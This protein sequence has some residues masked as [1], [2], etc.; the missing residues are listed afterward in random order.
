M[1]RRG[2]DEE[3][4][5]N[6]SYNHPHPNPWSPSAPPEAGKPPP[7]MGRELYMRFDIGIIFATF[8]SEI[9]SNKAMISWVIESTPYQEKVS[10][11]VDD[12]AISA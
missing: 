4:G 5:E 9:A 7:S 12:E 3:E 8:Y 1:T 10:A 6:K 2:G 11:L